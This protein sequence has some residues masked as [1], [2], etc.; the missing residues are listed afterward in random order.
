MSEAR[1]AGARLKEQE[2]DCGTQE[3]AVYPLGRQASSRPTGGSYLP[4]VKSGLRERKSLVYSE[5][6]NFVLGAMKLIQCIVGAVYSAGMT[7]QFR[8]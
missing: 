5:T 4:G 2:G 1:K 3:S 6:L 7:E 8:K